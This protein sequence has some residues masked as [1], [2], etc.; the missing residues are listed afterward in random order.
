MTTREV[1]E[2]INDDN[3]FATKV[4]AMKSAEDIYEAFKSIGLTDSFEIFKKESTAINDSI[5]KLSAA[6]VDAVAGGA[7]DTITTITTTTA[8]TIAAGAAI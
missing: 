2:K 3:E 7:T 1:Y 8:A 4:K 5:S 6:E